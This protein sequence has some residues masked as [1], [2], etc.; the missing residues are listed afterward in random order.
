MKKTKKND[1]KVWNLNFFLLWQGQMVSGIGDFFYQIALG[2]W[3]LDTTG[4]TAL[5]ATI[6]AA[7]TIPQIIISPIAGVVVDR[8]NRKWMIVVMDLVRGCTV[9]CIAI[10]AFIGQLEIWMVLFAGIILGVCLSFFNPAVQ[11]SIPDIVPRSKLV[12]ATAA[13]SMIFATSKIIGDAVG[14]FFYHILGVSLIFFVNGVSYLFSAFTE[15]FVKIPNIHHNREINPF[16]KEMKTGILFVWN[17]KGL[18]YL[19]LHA[20]ISNFFLNIS[21]SLILPLFQRNDQLGPVSYG[22]VMATA[23]IGA[24]VG[25]L[26]SSVIQFNPSRRF[27]MMCILGGVYS[28]A[29]MIFPFSQDIIVL[30][31]L[32]LIS[33]FAI[34]ISAN[35][36]EASIHAT[37]PANKRGKVFSLLNTVTMGVWPIGMIAGGILAEFIPIS[38]LI[39]TAS[40]ICLLGYMTLLFF[41]KAKQVINFDPTVQEGQEPFQFD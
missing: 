28:M 17:F 31:F 34:S 40:G 15:I 38:F 19:F 1:E 24:F 35:F 21:Y 14:G 33:G 16:F 9:M 26:L 11:A 39:T 18:R 29:R 2:F 3:V 13:F 27:L 10:I 37:V 22:F 5:M 12:K 25:L 6:M 32:M 41:P 36:F 7:S 30:L 8:V 23:A 20:L 4:S